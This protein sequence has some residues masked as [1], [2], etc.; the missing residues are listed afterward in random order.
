[1]I[2]LNFRLIVYACV[3]VCV[4][5]RIWKFYARSMCKGIP[6]KVERTM[7]CPGGSAVLKL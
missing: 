3:R 6:I 2:F 4:R 1:M 7:E 5:A